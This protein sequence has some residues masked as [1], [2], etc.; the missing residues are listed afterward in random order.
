MMRKSLT[1][2]RIK[3]GRA[4]IS[5]KTKK[6]LIIS[7]LSVEAKYKAMAKA[8]CEITWILGL[9]GDLEIQISKLVH[10]YC[11]NKAANDM[12]ANPMFHERT[13]HIET[14]CHF[15][16]EKNQKGVIKT[17]HICTLEQLANVF[18]KPLYSRQHSY[19]L[20]KL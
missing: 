16:R 9:L 7:F 4:L 10:L 11:D 12:V 20:H 2:F 5:W 1:D 8:T 3:L 17:L 14:D 19:L 15:I 13:K 6:Q 18:T